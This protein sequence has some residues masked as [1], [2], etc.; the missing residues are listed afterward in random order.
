MTRT[1]LPHSDRAD[2]LITIITVLRP[3]LLDGLVREYRF[4]PDRRWR[5]DVA[6]PRY[7][8]A[9]EVDG[10]QWMSGG[11]RHNTNADR[12]KLNTAAMHGWLVLRVSP[13]MLAMPERIIDMIEQTL[14]WRRDHEPHCN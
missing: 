9:V 1:R 2:E 5:F 14:R 11:G 10:G 13:S 4:H 3:S 12:E 7:R 6:F 8:V